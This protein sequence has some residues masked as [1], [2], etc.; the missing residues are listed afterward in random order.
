ML[1]RSTK[2]G[3]RLL[4]FGTRGLFSRVVLESLLAQGRNLV[5]LVV[6]SQSIYDWRALPPPPPLQT[7]LPLMASFV[8]HTI[9]EVGWRASIPVWEAGKRVTFGK[10]DGSADFMSTLQQLA[11][12]AIVVACWPTRL[13]N[14]LL[15]VP[16]WGGLNVHPSW[17][18][19]FRGPVPLFWQRRA[20]LNE[21]G[22]TIHC[23]NERLD[24]GEILAQAPFSLPDG[25]T[26]QELDL[27]AAQ[28]GG[29]LLGTVI[30]ALPHHHATSYSSPDRAPHRPC[31]QNGAGGG[32]SNPTGQACVPH[33]PAGSY[34]SWPKEQDFIVPTSWSARHAW[35]FMQ[36][37]SEWG[38]PFTIPLPEGPLKVRHAL[39]FAPTATLGA[40]IVYKKDRVAIQ[41]TPGVLHLRR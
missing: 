6:P 37:A 9:V 18:P 29:Q 21:S 34:Q 20:G 33:N 15:M 22:I 25:A 7:D 1:K 26:G 11:P 3:P 12:A 40:P 35:N 30:D 10:R 28:L 38:M 24:E 8:D 32:Y 13:S 23:M 17:L 4:F 36:A 14:G 27:L 2:Q 41:F 31:P 39:D 5:G 16:Q 19:H